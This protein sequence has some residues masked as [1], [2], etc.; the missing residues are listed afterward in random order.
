MS[1]RV[2]KVDHRQQ[3]NARQ[4]HALQMAAYAQE[5]ALLG[6]VDFPPLNRTIEEVQASTERFLGAFDH[7]VLVGAI[8]VG[9]GEEPGSWNIDSLVVSPARQ[10]EGIARHLMVATLE[11]H[12][13]GLMTVQ[14]GAKNAPALALYLRFGFVEFQ[15][16]FVGREPLELVRLRRIGQ[17]IARGG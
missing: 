11:Q 8:S 3:A 4:I 5:A 6:A 1:F 7:E 16:W 13:A 12:G 15:R 9:A 14:T 2:A 17:G 10:R